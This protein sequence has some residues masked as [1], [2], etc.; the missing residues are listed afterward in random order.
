MQDLMMKATTKETWGA[1]AATLPSD[2]ILVDEIGPIITTPATIGPDGEIV[3]PAVVDDHW[4]VN[5]RIISP[6]IDPA[7]IAQGA[8]GVEFVDSAIVTSPERIW[9]GG[10]NYYTPIASEQSNE[11]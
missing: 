3:T 11:G 4:H 6:D 8:P 5:L 9:A 7:V 10:M 1:F 2:G